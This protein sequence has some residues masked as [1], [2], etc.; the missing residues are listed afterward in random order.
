LALIFGIMNIV[1]LAH[2]ELYM[3]GAYLV[4]F[5]MVRNG[6]NIFLAAL[7]TV[8]IVGLLGVVL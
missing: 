6:L 3:L 7:I 8:L 4:H 5:F 1:Q 2:G